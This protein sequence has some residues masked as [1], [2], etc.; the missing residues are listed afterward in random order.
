MTNN[1]KIISYIRTGVPALIGALIAWL[2]SK[3]PAVAGG[4]SWVDAQFADAGFAG[5][6]A[7]GILTALGIA[8]ITT[9][10]YIVARW[11]G[12]RWPAL[13]KWLL[14]RSAVPVYF[15]HDEADTMSHKLPHVQDREVKEAVGEAVIVAEVHDE[16]KNRH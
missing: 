5:V 2:V 15:L 9:L 4:L 1:E 10:Y 6:T 8:G 11:A 3:I 7:Q 12:D 13:E 16:S 14:G